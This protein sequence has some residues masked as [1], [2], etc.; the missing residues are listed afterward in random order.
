MT[1]IF[2]GDVSET[3]SATLA[4]ITNAARGEENTTLAKEEEK[5]LILTELITKVWPNPSESFFN[6]NVKLKTAKMSLR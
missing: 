2:G 1:N 4:L 6:I 3:G 5:P